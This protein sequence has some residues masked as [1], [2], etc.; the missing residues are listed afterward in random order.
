MEEEKIKISWEEVEEKEIY[1]EALAEGDTV[2]GVIIQ[3]DDTSFGNR[4]KLENVKEDKLYILPQ[5]KNLQSKLDQLG[6]G[7]TVR[8]TYKMSKPTKKGNDYIIYKVEVASFT[9]V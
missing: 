8:V 3:I 6:V 2:Q 7:D 1:W 5:H 4:Y 9:G